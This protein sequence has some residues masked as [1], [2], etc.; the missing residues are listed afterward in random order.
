MLPSDVLPQDG[1]RH[2]LRFVAFL[3]LGQLVY[4]PHRVN[5]LTGSSNNFASRGQLSSLPPGVNLYLCLIIMRQLISLLLWVNW[6]LCLMLVS[7]PHGVNCYLCLMGVNWYLCLMGAKWSLCLI[8]STGICLMG[9]AGICLM[10]ETG[11]F[12]S[13][14]QL[15]SLPLMGST[16]LFAS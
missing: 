3:S 7:F 10:R 8:G 9:F 6:Y 11:L 13:W 15:V 16:G 12:A 5:T 14:S 1:K 2:L 4:S